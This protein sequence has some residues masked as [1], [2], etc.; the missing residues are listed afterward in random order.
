[1]A[2]LLEQLQQKLQPNYKTTIIQ[3]HQ[4]VELYGS[5]TSKE[6]K[7]S[8]SDFQPR[9]R[10]RETDCASSHTQKKDNNNLNTKNN[11]K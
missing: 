2:H 9:W 11:Q 3:N 6:L 8:N 7:K 1:M 10:H 4:K 5:P